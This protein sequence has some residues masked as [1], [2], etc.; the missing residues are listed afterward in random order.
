ML[1][2]VCTTSF[3]NWCLITWINRNFIHP[4]F[5]LTLNHIKKRDFRIFKKK[6]WTSNKKFS[7]LK[8]NEDK[9]STFIRGIFK[10]QETQMDEYVKKMMTLETSNYSFGLN[11]W[12]CDINDNAENKRYMIFKRT[13]EMSLYQKFFT[14]YWISEFFEFL[15]LVFFTSS[16]N[17]FM[18]TAIPANLVLFLTPL[19]ASF[20]SKQKKRMK[21]L[22]RLVVTLSLGLSCVYNF[23]MMEVPFLSWRFNLMRLLQGPS[24]IEFVFGAVAILLNLG[25]QILQWALYAEYNGMAFNLFFKVKIVITLILISMTAILFKQKV[26]YFSLKEFSLKNFPLKNFPLKNFPLMNF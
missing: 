18:D 5:Y 19:A 17:L 9:L 22:I 1:A 2:T 12:T 20:L 25:I 15:A 24:H 7:F 16:S 6:Y 10:A 3:F 8:Q 21:L 14:I 13:W 26:S 11:E 4:L 23:V